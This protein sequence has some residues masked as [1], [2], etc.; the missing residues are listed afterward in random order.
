MNIFVTNANPIVCAE[1]HCDVHL[2]KMIVE[3]AQ[4][5]STAHVELDGVQVAY[6][7]THK[8]HP[9]CVWV[10]SDYKNYRW[11]SALLY[12]L[13]KEYKIRFDKEHKTLEH[14]PALVCPP[15]NITGT[16]LNKSGFMRPEGF[17]MAMPDEY[18]SISVETAYQR[19]LNDKFKE[20]RSRERP[21]KVEWTNR[22][23]PDWVSL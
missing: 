23:T 3:T 8:N 12:F 18:K 20:W 2:R 9:S 13:L 4:L 10:R 5:L 6:K 14:Y 19:Y 17:V 11:A 1:E 16:R 22:S 21:M 15:K 7:S